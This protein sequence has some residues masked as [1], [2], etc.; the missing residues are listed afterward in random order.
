M[1]NTSNRDKKSKESLLVNSLEKIKM[2]KSEL[3]KNI[4]SLLI[5]N[6]KLKIQYD[7]DIRQHRLTIL[8]LEKNIEKIE[9]DLEEKNKE[10]TM[11]RDE[12]DSYE[13]YE[14]ESSDSSNIFISQ[15]NK[16][17]LREY[18]LVFI[19]CILIYSVILNGLVARIIE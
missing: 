16:K 7:T 4:V 14:P 2:C 1:T 15:V 19:G 5:E 11:L 13:I 8:N 18:M 6:D 10:V 9:K 12:I 17:M 3:R